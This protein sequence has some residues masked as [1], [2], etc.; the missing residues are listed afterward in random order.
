M[1]KSRLTHEL[2]EVVEVSLAAYRGWRLT[3]SLHARLWAHFRQTIPFQAAVRVKCRGS[4]PTASIIVV[5][6]G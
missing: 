3:L 5:R 1:A 4:L 2:D 6:C